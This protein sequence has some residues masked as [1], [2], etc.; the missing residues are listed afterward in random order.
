MVFFKLCNK[1][2][3][4]EGKNYFKLIKIENF[5]DDLPIPLAGK[6]WFH[7]KPNPTSVGTKRSLFWQNSMKRQQVVG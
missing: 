4:H 2:A 1:E 3:T 5:L 7:A 6:T